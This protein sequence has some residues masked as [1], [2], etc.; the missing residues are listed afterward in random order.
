[1]TAVGLEEM[2]CSPS[3]IAGFGLTPS[4]AC[5]GLNADNYLAARVRISKHNQ[6]QRKKTH[7]S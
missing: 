1:M 6:I 3:L 7:I 5:I 2:C 4:I